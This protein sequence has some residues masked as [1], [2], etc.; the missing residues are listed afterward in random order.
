MCIEA[1]VNATHAFAHLTEQV[2]GSHNRQ[3]VFLGF[4]VPVHTYSAQG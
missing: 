3:G 4:V 2:L 1:I